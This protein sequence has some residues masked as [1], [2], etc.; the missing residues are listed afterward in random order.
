MIKTIYICDKCGAEITS[1]QPKNQQTQIFD[2]K[3]SGYQRIYT[4][5]SGELCMVL[6][7]Q[8]LDEY[9][10][11]VSKNKAEQ[12]EKILNFFKIEKQGD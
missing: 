9:H 4:D 10:K 5:E 3:D 11:L 12:T 2:I 7:P 6:C 1:E 8:C